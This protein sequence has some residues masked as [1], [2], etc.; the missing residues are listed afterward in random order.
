MN[1]VIESKLEML[2]E[3]VAI[4]NDHFQGETETT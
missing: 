1:D 3:Y 4:L 2:E